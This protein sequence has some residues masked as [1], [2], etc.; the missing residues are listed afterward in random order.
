MEL[1]GTEFFQKVDYLAG[2]WWPAR[3]IVER[4]IAQ[5]TE[6]HPSGSIVVLDQFCPWKEHLFEIE[7]EVGIKYHAT[8]AYNIDDLYMWSSWE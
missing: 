8:I 7:D 3:A 4:C 1:T 2:A 6:V 5:R